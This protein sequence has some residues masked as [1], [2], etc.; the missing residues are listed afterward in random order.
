MKSRALSISLA[1]MLTALPLSGCLTLAAVHQLHEQHEFERRNAFDPSA[2]EWA[3][4]PGAPIAGR[5]TLTASYRQGYSG[6][7]EPIPDETL[8]CEQLF[9]RLI[10]DTPHMRWL[11]ERQHRLIVTERGDW[12][13]GFSEQPERWS[14]PEA[15][16]AS[17]IRETTCGTGGAFSFPSVPAGPYLLLA[18][19]HPTAERAPLVQNDIVLKSVMVKAGA[20]LNVHIRSRNALHGPLTPR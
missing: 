19:L 1:V 8:T 13:N 20:P 7:V 9:I 5:L 14:W 4:A 17:Y 12:L 18:Q 2:H 3:L 15:A 6:V 10:P 16:S 11:L